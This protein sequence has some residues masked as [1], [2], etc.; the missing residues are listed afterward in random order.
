MIGHKDVDLRAADSNGE[1]ALHIAV[2]KGQAPIISALL[3]RPEVDISA[4]NNDG[5]SALDIAKNLKQKATEELLKREIEKREKIEKSS[6]AA[7]G[8]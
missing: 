5:E 1:T 3:K 7:R 8:R 6:A 2:R 4:L